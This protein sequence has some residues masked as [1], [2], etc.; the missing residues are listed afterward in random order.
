M[1]MQLEKEITSRFDAIT[2]IIWNNRNHRICKKIL[3]VVYRY[4]VY[5]WKLLLYSCLFGRAM[6]PLGGRVSENAGNGMIKILVTRRSSRRVAPAMCP[7]PSWCFSMVWTVI[8]HMDSCKDRRLF[9]KYAA[10]VACA[11]AHAGGELK[12]TLVLQPGWTHKSE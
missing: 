5:I 12:V 10:H 2:F 3:H 7:F 8:Y 1:Y 11:R 4:S 9:W 6:T